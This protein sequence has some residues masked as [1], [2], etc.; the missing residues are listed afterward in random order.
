MTNFQIL[1]GGF[2]SFL[3]VME[4]LL[5]LTGNARRSIGLL[6]ISTWISAIVLLLNPQITV[7]I[8]AAMSIGR[9]ADLL[10]YT[11]V[12]AF[13]VSF[14]FMLHAIERQREQLTALVR[15]LAIM[16]PYAQP[17]EAQDIKA[18]N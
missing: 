7:R 10:L 11:L 3:L 1:A 14:F 16:K 5:Q 15:Q 13:L 2:L 18:D 9:G 17:E 8:A 4:V 6:R 12:L